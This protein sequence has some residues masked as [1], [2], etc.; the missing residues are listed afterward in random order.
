M[1]EDENRGLKDLGPLAISD[2]E[3]QVSTEPGLGHRRGWD[4][5]DQTTKAKITVTERFG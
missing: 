2:G 4:R 3:L 5:L 1:D